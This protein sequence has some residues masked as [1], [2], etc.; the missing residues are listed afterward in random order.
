M[1]KPKYDVDTVKWTEEELRYLAKMAG[2][3]QGEAL[4]KALNEWRIQDRAELLS[5]NTDHDRTQFVR[6]RLSLLQD[7]VL[8]LEQDAPARYESLLKSQN[9]PDSEAP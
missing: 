5:P 2:S 6:G 3:P 9:K 4:Q 8:L 7:L 1:P